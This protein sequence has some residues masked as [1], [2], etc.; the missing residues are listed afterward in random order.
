MSWQRSILDASPAPPPT[1]ATE[2]TRP[3]TGSALGAPHDGLAAAVSVMTMLMVVTLT[4]LTGCERASPGEGDKHHAHQ[5]DVPV[6]SFS[7]AVNALGNR[8]AR[9]VSGPIIQEASL[10]SQKLR[11]MAEIVEVLPEAASDTDLK[12][13]EWDR[14]NAISQQLKEILH[15]VRF[16][17][18]DVARQSA[19]RL[20]SLVSELDRLNRSRQAH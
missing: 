15:P 16:S 5:H 19:Q 3:E 6:H 1:D 8:S 7:E 13:T 9:F 10:E 11:A 14:V 12:K 4:S 18:R 20:Q 2:R 17:S